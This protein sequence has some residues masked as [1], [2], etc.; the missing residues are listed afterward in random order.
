MHQ[1]KFGIF[2][3]KRVKE[4]KKKRI[5]FSLYLKAQECIQKSEYNYDKKKQ[6][7]NNLRDQ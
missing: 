5:F 2:R 1:L 7:N 6:I 4:Q 3:G